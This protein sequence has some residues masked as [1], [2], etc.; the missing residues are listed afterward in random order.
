M[1]VV[2]AL[3]ILERG[4]SFPALVRKKGKLKHKN[5]YLFEIINAG[6]KDALV[7]FAG[8]IDAHKG[9]YS[10]R[11]SHFPQNTTVRAGDAFDGFIGA[12][13][14]KTRVVAGAAL[15]INIL[16]GHLPG[17][18]EFING[19]LR[20]HKSSFPVGYGDSVDISGFNVA[21]PR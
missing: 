21:E 8:N 4:L 2:G 15:Q 13:G 11:M 17:G 19:L 16:G 5:Y 9:A 7:F 1:G 6:G 12:V 20:S 14:V 10:F 3:P 18:K